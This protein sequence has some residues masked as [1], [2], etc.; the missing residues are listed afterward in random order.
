M[1]LDVL[2]GGAFLADLEG[3]AREDE[4]ILSWLATVT[5]LTGDR[6]RG[7]YLVALVA[8]DTD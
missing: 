5:F 1:A 2:A 8:R 4:R 7:V 6:P 3:A